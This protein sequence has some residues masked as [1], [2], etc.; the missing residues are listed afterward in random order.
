MVY[1]T[2]HHTTSDNAFHFDSEYYVTS[3]ISWTCPSS[4]ASDV[5]YH[6]SHHIMFYVVMLGRATLPN[7]IFFYTGL[8]HTF[9]YHIF[10]TTYLHIGCSI[11][12]SC[13]AMPCLCYVVFFYVRLS[14]CLRFW[15]VR[16]VR[17]CY[18]LW[19]YAM[20]CYAVLF[21]LPKLCYCI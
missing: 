16:Y 8:P 9:Q 20:A 17:L 5:F 19:C 11:L 3:Y 7:T 2:L 15:C 14:C 6:I 12:L 1:I 21:R 13:Y 4:V 10:I 18:A